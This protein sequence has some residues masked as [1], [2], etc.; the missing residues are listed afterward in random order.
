MN[1]DNITIIGSD[2]AGGE[3]QDIIINIQTEAAD[4]VLA[5]LADIDVD[6]AAIKV[7]TDELTFTKTNELDAN[8]KSVN[9]TTVV[10][11]GQTGTEWGP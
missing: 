6:V 10:G 7:K 5:I 3:W 8:I 9:D 4:T 2:V 1:G 11:D